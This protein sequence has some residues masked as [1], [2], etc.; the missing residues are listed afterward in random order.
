M[1]LST[2]INGRDGCHPEGGGEMKRTK[3]VR[4]VEKSL[5][6]H[7]DVCPVCKAGLSCAEA[8][9][10]VTRVQATRDAELVHPPKKRRRRLGIF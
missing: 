4:A 8:G 2:E 5:M 7:A 9:A 3:R 6:R 1:F 10:M